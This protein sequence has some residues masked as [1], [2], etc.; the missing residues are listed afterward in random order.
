MSSVRRKTILRY[1]IRSLGAVRTRVCCAAGSSAAS[2]APIATSKSSP[3]IAITPVIESVASCSTSALRPTNRDAS[4]G[5]RIEDISAK[6]VCSPSM[7]TPRRT[8]DASARSTTCCRLST[9]LRIVA[10]VGSARIAVFRSSPTCAAVILNCG[11]NCNC[12][13]RS[14]ISHPKVSNTGRLSRRSSV[15]WSFSK[16]LQCYSKYLNINAIII[17]N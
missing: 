7:G 17:L 14:K 9:E 13:R 1:S 10:V 4:R 15:E 2:A 3:Y 6:R 11:A 5:C 12:S 16:V 8:L